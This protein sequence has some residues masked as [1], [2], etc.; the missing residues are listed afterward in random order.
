ME[1]L[2]GILETVLYVVGG[3]LGVAGLILVIKF[4]IGMGK[5][6]KETESLKKDLGSRL[7][8]IKDLNYRKNTRSTPK[9]QYKNKI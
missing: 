9:V 3:T 6:D 4:I 7:D 1:A 8:G 5:I 2:G